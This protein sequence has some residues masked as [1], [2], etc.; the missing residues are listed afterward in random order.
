MRAVK[1]RIVDYGGVK[2][3]YCPTKTEVEKISANLTFENPEYSRAVRFGR[4][5]QKISPN[6]HYFDL[7]EKSITVPSATILDPFLSLTDTLYVDERITND[8]VLPDFKLKLRPMQEEAKTAYLR[9]A[10]SLTKPK[11]IIQL[12]TGKGKT[13]LGLAI[14]HALHQKTLVIVHKV[15]LMD[16]WEADA[17]K[18]F[19][20][21]IKIDRIQGAKNVHFSSPICIATIQTLNLLPEDILSTLFVQFGLIIHDEMH[22]CPASSYTLALHFGAKYRLGLTATPERSDGLDFIMNLFYGDFAYKYQAPEHALDEK[23]ILPVDVF[24]VSMPQVEFNPICTQIGADRWIIRSDD[25][26]NAQPDTPLKKNQKRILDF[27]YYSQR[28]KVSYFEA[29]EFTVLCPHTINRL[30]K[31]IEFE[32]RRGSCIVVFVQK[33]AHVEFLFDTLKELYP[34][35]VVTY[36]GGNNKAENGVNKEKIDNDKDIITIATY[37]KAMEGTNVVN[38]SVGILL[39]SQADQ[40]NTEQVVGRVRRIGEGKSDRARIYDFDYS[41]SYLLG[42]HWYKRASRYKKL[43]FKIQTSTV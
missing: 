41:N 7:G 24:R 32:K 35:K 31:I 40:K 34:D 20:D 27:K 36:Y 1:R 3:F 19:G 4:Y 2:T 13:V 42:Q 43:G 22:H 15:D 18:V 8:V 25:D 21:D 33:R 9:G 5:A 29:D 11:N 26:L 37:K 14:A 30:L 6:L 38:W 17:K 28:P 12:P 10:G 23:D 39:S 16:S